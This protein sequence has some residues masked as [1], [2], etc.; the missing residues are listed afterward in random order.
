ME[1]IDNLDRKILEIISQDARKPFKEVA[2]V[3]DVS[4][5][6]IHQRVQKMIEMKVIVGSGYQI[7]PVSLG[8]NTCTYIGV[9]LERGS[10]YK[11]VV[12][13]LEKIPEIVECHFTTGPYTLLLKLYARD[14]EHFT[15]LLNGRIQ[16]IPGVISTET[17]ISLKQSIKRGIPIEEEE[18]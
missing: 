17:L 12:P 18:I 4:R 6:A 5:A 11:D 2:E 13:E 16:E 8:Y 1:K 7:N 14:N 3:C 9:K 15:E 10:M